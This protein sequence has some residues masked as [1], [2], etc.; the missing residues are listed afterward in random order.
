MK[1]VKLG[2]AMSK[3]LIAL[4]VFSSFSGVYLG[5][6]CYDT[7]S[8][9]FVTEAIDMGYFASRVFVINIILFL[10][11]AW[12]YMCGILSF[13]N[14]FV[15][16]TNSFISSFS[17]MIFLYYG[18]FSNVALVLIACVYILCNLIL[19]INSHRACIVCI[20][21]YRRGVL[22]SSSPAKLVLS[23]VLVIA[24]LLFGVILVY[25]ALVYIFNENI[26]IFTM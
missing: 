5:S 19:I 23:A 17:Y 8:V 4:L 25:F 26:A 11:S 12:S 24:M 16:F 21:T 15:V 3:F 2:Q 18:N 13:F 6:G 1:I 22:L 7:L 9:V 20:K 10:F 14:I